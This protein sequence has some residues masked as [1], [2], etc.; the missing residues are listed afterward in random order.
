MCNICVTEMLCLEENNS[1][2]KEKVAAQQDALQA[3]GKNTDGLVHHCENCY[4][5]QIFSSQYIVVTM[6]IREKSQA[7]ETEW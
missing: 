1:I 4:N 2:L 5:S 6:G 3:L 7:H